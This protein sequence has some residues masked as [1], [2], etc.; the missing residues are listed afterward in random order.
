MEA[1]PICERCSA[2]D[3]QARFHRCLA[4]DFSDPAYGVVHHLVVA[5]YG[6]QHGWYTE[7]SEP[8][9]VA[10]VLSHLDRHP[11]E[12]DRQQ[13]RLATEGAVRVRARDPR[14]VAV[15][16]DRSV[17]DVDVTDADAYVATVRGWAGS[18]AR[19]LGDALGRRTQEG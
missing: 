15:S 14:S 6:L 8:R 1:V 12:H 4:A 17:A 5:A 18:V 10:F 2:D 13:I 19:T 11:T 3:C 16:W 7:E 9:M